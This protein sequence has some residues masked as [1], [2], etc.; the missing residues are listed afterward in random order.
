MQF[1]E[2]RVHKDSRRAG[3]YDIIPGFEGDMN[4]T[5]HTPLV[6]PSELHMHKHQTDYFAVAEG[7][8]LFRLVYEDGRLEEKFILSTDD[9]RTL[10]IPPGIWHGYMALEPSIM[11]FYISHKFDISDEFR[12]PCY[13]EEW[14]F[15]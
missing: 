4:F 13:P 14:Q 10:I 6:I 2:H 7:K 5:K 9:F 12:R 11:I 8:V 15:E 3:S 1:H